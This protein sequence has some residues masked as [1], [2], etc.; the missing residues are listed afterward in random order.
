[1][2]YQRG[3]QGTS[4][5]KILFRVL[6]VIACLAVVSTATVI[7]GNHLKDKA[8]KSAMG[9]SE[10]AGRPIDALADSQNDLS[11]TSFSKS[12]NV[13]SAC[14]ILS[15]LN[16]ENTDNLTD[17]ESNMTFEEKA[18][19]LI[20][21]YAD[22]GYTGISVVMYGKDGYLTYSSDVVS[23]Y[24]HQK[25]ASLTSLEQ[26]KYLTSK[27]KGMSLRTTA[28]IFSSSDFTTNTVSYDIEALCVADSASC[29]FDEVLAIL[30]VLS[31]EIDSSMSASIIKYISNLSQAK[32][33]SLLGIALGDDVYRVPQLSPQIELFA[34]GCD[35]L[36]IDLSYLFNDSE[37][38]IS[39]IEGAVEELS[40]SFNV[41]GLR[42][43]LGGKD[44]EIS[45]K[46][47]DALSKGGFSNYVFTDRYIEEEVISDDNGNE[48]TTEIEG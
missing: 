31:T 28:L 34:S 35:F 5:K 40:G 16:E 19:E 22:E 25:S 7:Y 41:Y 6:I 3:Y 24:T 8:E 10:G 23:K 46:S 2:N 33:D 29:G 38:V 14:V 26:L 39:K 44:K 47:V 48:E 18:T 12:V 17:G 9:S 1:M 45:E 30:P 15:R 37:T 4:K 42:A 11:N 27:A 13:K 43:V 36:G 21:D 32:G 20:Q